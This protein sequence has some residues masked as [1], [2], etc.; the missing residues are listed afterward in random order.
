MDQNRL[1][2]R[3]LSRS[4]FNFIINDYSPPDPW[5]DTTSKSIIADLN[6]GDK[7]NGENYDIWSR[8]M[9][10]VLEEQDALESINHVMSHPDEGN[11]AQHKRDLETYNVWKKKDSTIREIIVSSVADDLIYECE[12]YPTAQAMW[13]YLRE[14]YGGTT[15]TRLR[16]LTIK[17]DTYKKRHDHGVKQHLRVM[18][19]MIAQLKSVGHVLSDEQQVQAMFRSLPNNWEHFKVNLSHNDSIKTFVDIVRHVELE[20]ERLGA[21]KV[22]LNAFVVESS[23]TKRSSFKHNRN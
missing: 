16:Q 15:V 17:F 2:G 19:N 7:L 13:A 5:P 8:K 21:A 14:A 23:G 10:Y 3:G 6:K 4:V 22:V 11:T 1:G 20:D 9:W 18:S 12:Q